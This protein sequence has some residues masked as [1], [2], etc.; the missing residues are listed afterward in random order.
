MKKKRKHHTHTHRRNI[1]PTPI[2]DAVEVELDVIPSPPSPPITPSGPSPRRSPIASESHDVDGE[3]QPPP[4]PPPF[5]L[6]EDDVDS[7]PHDVEVVNE[8]KERKSTVESG[9]DSSNRVQTEHADDGVAAPDLP[10]PSSAPTL[11]SHNSDSSS[12]LVD[13]SLTSH[14][15]PSP[16]IPF[17]D[18]DDLSW[19]DPVL[20]PSEPVTLSPSTPHTS[21]PS[22]RSTSFTLPSV[23][24]NSLSTSPPSEP[25]YPPIQASTPPSP[26]SH[27]NVSPPASPLSPASPHS[28]ASP[29]LLVDH[30]PPSQRV[31]FPARSDSFPNRPDS[32]PSHLI[33]DSS[34]SHSPSD[35]SSRAST[36]APLFSSHLA[37]D[38]SDVLHLS[39]PPL[40]PSLLVSLLIVVGG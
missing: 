39:S 25:L 4:R 9:S 35:S 20:S 29:Q 16:P 11:T 17:T 30:R 18:E 32:S 33:I 6:E 19:L 22:P 3:T 31:T 8:E 13:S 12:S 1:Q 21:S 40:P 38:S 5:S 36:A 23:S 24:A 27:P 15:S 10:P 14:A 26:P 37:G 34:P 28:L 2:Y 7:L